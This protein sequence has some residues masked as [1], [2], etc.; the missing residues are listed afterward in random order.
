MLRS[1]VWLDPQTHQ[2]WS[3]LRILAAPRVWGTGYDVRVNA[4]RTEGN[5][6][7]PAAVFTSRLNLTAP[8]CVLE[9]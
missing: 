8:S 1:R 7:Q 5:E 9:C 4:R 3:L 6:S 2:V